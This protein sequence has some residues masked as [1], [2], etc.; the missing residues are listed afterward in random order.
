MLPLSWKLPY[1]LTEARPTFIDQ[2]PPH[3]HALSPK[4]VSIALTPDQANAIG[5]QIAGHHNW[6]EPCSS[7]PLARI[8]EQLTSAIESI[9][10]PCFVRLTTRSPK[11]SVRGNMQGFRVYN[12]HEALG[13][14]LSGSTRCANDL[15]MSLVYQVPIAIVIRPWIDCTPLNEFRCFMVK[16]KLVGICP[17]LKQARVSH[18]RFELNATSVVRSIAKTMALVMPNAT[19]ENAAFDLV[20]QPLS[21][22]TEVVALLLNANPLGQQ[23]DYGLF[24]GIADLN[25]TFRM[26]LEPLAAHADSKVRSIFINTII[27]S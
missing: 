8:I 21:T 7:A 24:N 15:K 26:T 25:E 13:L 2:W 12:G 9:G 19:I 27:L 23:T 20:L 22:S 4:S 1:N 3:W 14:I 5:Y 6:F 17:V 10:S 11:D 18:T 16:P